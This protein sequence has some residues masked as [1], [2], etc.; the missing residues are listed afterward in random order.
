[1]ARPDLPGL[2][3][4]DACIL[5]S[6]LKEELHPAVTPLVRMTLEGQFEAA[7]SSLHYVEVIGK[8]RNQPF[9]QELENRVLDLIEAPVFR[10]IDIGPDV[11]IKARQYVLHEGLKSCDAMHVAAAVV[12]GCDV[13]MTLDG[14]LQKRFGSCRQIDGVWIDEAYLPSDDP[15][16]I[17]GL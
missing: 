8:N 5:I 14:G 9:D 16:A 10:M 4:F 13:L 1:V 6:Y 15:G 17:K 2:I 7:I 12:G 3:Y 11:Q